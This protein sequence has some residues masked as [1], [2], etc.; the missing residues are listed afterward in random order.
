MALE[1]QWLFGFTSKAELEESHAV[2]ALVF[3]ILCP[4]IPLAVSLHHSV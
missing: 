4:A 3:P 2:T 1:F